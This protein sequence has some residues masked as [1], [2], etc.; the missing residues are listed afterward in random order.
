MGEPTEEDRQR[1]RAE[2]LRAQIEDLRR[3]V[4]DP[5]QP[6]SPR[7]F[8]DNAVREAGLPPDEEGPA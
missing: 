7:E 1:Q 5:S 3:G 6:E 8:T 2:D 4:R